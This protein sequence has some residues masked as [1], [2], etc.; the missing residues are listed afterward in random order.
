[1]YHLETSKLLSN[2]Q[3][4]FRK[5]RSTIDHLVRLER[6]IREA[7]ANKEHLVAIFFDL[8]KAF[9]T[10]WKHGILKDLHGL[11]LRG[12]LPEFVRN[13]L[14]NRRFCTK[15]GN[16]FS[17][18][19]DQEEG[20][21]QGSILSPILFEIKINSITQTLVAHSDCSLYVD[22][23]LVCY[24][25]KTKGRMD[26]VERQLQA[27]LK[28]LEEW[29][30]SNGFRF[31]PSKTVAVHFC[32]DRKCVRD[33]DLYLYKS[34]I[35]VRGEARF[36]GLIFDR[37]LSFL[38]HIKDLR[39]RCQKALNALKV[40]SSP[41]WGGGADILLN[42]YRSLVRSK[43][44]YGCFVYGGARASYIKQLDPIHHQG[45]RCALGAFRTSPVESLLAEAGEQPLHLR[46]RKLGLQYALKVKSTPAN[47]AFQSIF[48][49]SEN[50][51]K[52]F[53]EHPTKIPPFGLRVKE[54]FEDLED[55]ITPFRFSSIPPWE[56][57]RPE[58]DLSL[59]SLQKASTSQKTFLDS[60]E[61]LKQKY[62][63]NSFIYTDGSKGS[64]GVGAAACSDFDLGMK[65]LN[66][67]AS[68]F[69][70]ESA[71]IELAL[72]EIQKSSDKSFVI[73]SDSL[74]L[75][76]ALQ[77]FKVSD[78]RVLS[79]VERVHHLSQ[80]KKIVFAW[81]PG[82]MGIPG[83]DRADSLARAAVHLEPREDEPLC[84]TD[85]RPVIKT[86]FTN[87]FKNSWDIQQTNK[88]HD[89]MPELRP[90]SAP[91]LNRR[92]DS[93]LR[94]LR[95]GHTPLTH[96]YLLTGDPPPVCDQCGQPQ[97]VRHILLD[98]DFYSTQRKKYFKVK[99]MSLLFNKDIVKENQVIS[100]L[101]EIGLLSRL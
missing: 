44:D 70:A 47:P 76:T 97:S 30:D 59:S 19:Q 66:S 5:N 24:K 43:L 41:E 90:F 3:C 22:D 85:L 42:L 54:D 49:F 4:G 40:L 20:V 63:D 31:S 95:I 17:D 80:Q 74:S 1:M 7:F 77:S 100:Y 91:Q 58:V 75:L 71:A 61:T 15:V 27:Q 72:D 46:R 96:S 65:K 69:S 16:S 28:R 37:K 21:P 9:D 2:F 39:L 67:C 29:A 53:V 23:F 68:V 38:P 33:P 8:E 78:T 52:T 60:F 83:N 25:G 99:R 13:F 55:E 18:P 79:I 64:S 82:H 11:G 12:H 36:L 10:T 89:V 98:C 34:R 84:H 93:L 6:F 92:H 26:T 32:C 35:P 88:L 101:K 51:V 62:P 87:I 50:N 81:V 14:A 86:A 94:R 48:H 45:L 56:L 57:V 73:F